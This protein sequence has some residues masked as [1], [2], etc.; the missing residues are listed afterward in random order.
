MGY[1]KQ[2]SMY[3]CS[4]LNGFRDSVISLYNSKIVANK[5]ILCALYNAGIYCSNNKVGRV[6][7]V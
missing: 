6:Y 5:E 7:L 1:S 3:V 2:K 4:I